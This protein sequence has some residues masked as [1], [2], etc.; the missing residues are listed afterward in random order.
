MKIMI[1]TLGTRGDVQPFVALAGALAGAGHEAVLCGPHRFADFA[2]EHGV[3][4]AGVDD[5]PMRL[6]DAPAEAGAALIQGG[7]RARLGQIRLMPAM[8]TQLLTECWQVASDGAG[9]GADVVVHNGQILAGQHVAEAL[10]VPAVLGLPLPMYLP[11]RAFPW[12]GSSTPTWLPPA[13]NRVTYTGMKLPAVVFGR[14]ID[15]WR[16]G[17]LGLP[18][19]PR[20]H[21]PTRRPDGRAATVLHAHSPAVLPRPGD[22]PVGAEVTGYWFVPPAPALPEA[23]EEFLAAGPSPVFAGFGSMTGMNPESVTNAVVE[24]AAAVGRRLIVAAGWG[25]IDGDGAVNAADR[26]GV[27]CVVVGEV[28]Y[29]L[30]FPRVAVVVHHGGAGTTGVAFAAGRPQVICPFAVDQPFW[31]RLAHARGVA[32]SPLPQKYLTAAA[33]ADRLRTALR[34]GTSAAAEAIGAQ[35]HAETGLHAAVEAIERTAYQATKS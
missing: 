28:D 17:T 34:P 4:Y 2:T 7:V 9:A 12:P 20:R 21:D 3:S 33:L 24:A 27:E 10:D 19:R 11:T 35:V 8:F 29:Q 18:S 25:G 5:G 23:V 30:L 22:W 6:L 32:P 13:L 15:R 26:L 16:R 14:V 31:G 1:M